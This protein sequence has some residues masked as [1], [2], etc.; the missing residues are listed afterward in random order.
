[1]IHGVTQ[2]Q[3]VYK[4]ALDDGDEVKKYQIKQI[5]NKHFLPLLLLS[6]TH[7]CHLGA[8]LSFK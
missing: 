8:M 1:M 4:E 6:K 3:D 5:Q 2:G 7:T